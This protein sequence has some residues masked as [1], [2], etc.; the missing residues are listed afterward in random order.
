MSNTYGASA[1]AQAPYA[2]A[3]YAGAGVGV[4]PTYLYAPTLWTSADVASAFAVSS[5]VT[6]TVGLVAVCDG[7]LTPAGQPRQLKVVV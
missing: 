5:W 4:Q 3:T 2:E 7:G 1:Y 6:E